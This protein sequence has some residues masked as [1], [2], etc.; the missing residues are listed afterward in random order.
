MNR[1]VTVSAPGKLMLFGDHAVVYG[2]PCI[3]AAVNS[4][5]RVSIAVREDDRILLDAPDV[6]LHY[7][8]R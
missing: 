4:R 6:E 1:R 2:K 5:M 7:A 3:V 8:P